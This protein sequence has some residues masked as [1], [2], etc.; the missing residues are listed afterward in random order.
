MDQRGRTPCTAA[1][2]HKWIVCMAVMDHAAISQ[3]TAQ[4]I[5][6]VTHHSVSASTI[7]RHLQQRGM[8]ARRPFPCLP[9][10]R[11]QGCLRQKW[12]DE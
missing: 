2:D 7:R 10:I 4:Q 12:C 3:T 9:L 11:K 8:S 1:R 5:L 6:S